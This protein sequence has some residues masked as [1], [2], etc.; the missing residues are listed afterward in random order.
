M[1]IDLNKWFAEEENEKQYTVKDLEILEQLKAIGWSE[2]YLEI[3]KL[4]Q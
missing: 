1:E 2:D 4:W 3:W